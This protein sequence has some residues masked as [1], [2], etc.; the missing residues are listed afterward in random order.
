MVIVAG[1]EVDA[2]KFV[3]PPKLAVIVCVPGARNVAG[4]QAAT[5]FT[6]GAAPTVFPFSKNSTAPFGVASVDDTVAWRSAPRAW[7]SVVELDVLH[8]PRSATNVS[9]GRFVIP[10]IA[11]S[12]ICHP[13]GKAVMLPVPMRKRMRTR[14]PAYFVPRSMRT[15]VNGDA[16]GDSNEAPGLSPANARRP[17][18]GFVGSAT[19]GVAS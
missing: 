2:V 6:S 3:V 7:I 5:P 14:W 16:E 11:T 12:S 10:L 19:I 18:S 17:A 15:V 13:S 4:F 1:A 8:R 9:N